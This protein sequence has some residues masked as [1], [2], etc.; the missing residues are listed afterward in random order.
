M[1]GMPRDELNAPEI[2]FLVAVMVG[3]GNRNLRLSGAARH[4]SRM[5][6]IRGSGDGSRER[7]S[8][9]RRRKFLRLAAGRIAVAVASASDHV[10]DQF[11][12][13]AVLYLLNAVGKNHKL[14]IHLIQFATFKLVSQLFAAQSQ[15]VAARV[16]PQHQ[17]RIGTPTD[18]GVMIS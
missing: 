8:R 15:R 18:C 9:R 16:F 17:P 14:A 1:V 7:Q 2:V 5:R 4:L 13:M 10:L 6:V 3:E 11:D 12:Q